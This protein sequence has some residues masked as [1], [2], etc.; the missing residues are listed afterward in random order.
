MDNQDPVSVTRIHWRKLFPWLNLLQAAWIGVRV[1]IL[2]PAAVLLMVSAA[3]PQLD[4]AALTDDRPWLTL[5][6]PV[7]AIVYSVERI[8]L[9][10]GLPEAKSAAVLVWNVLVLGFLGLAIARSSASEFCVGVRV[11]AIAGLRFAA[12]RAFAWLL[13][14]GIAVLLAAVFA[15]P[16]LVVIGISQWWFHDTILPQALWLASAVLAVLALLAGSVCL[17]GWFLAMAAIGTDNCSGSDALSR[18]ISYVLSHPWST[19]WQLLIITVAAS[20]VRQITAVVLTASLLLLHSRA[21][22]TYPL[23]AVDLSTVFAKVPDVS[24]GLLAHLPDLTHLGVFLS[25]LTVMYVL[26]RQKEDGIQLQE[27]DGSRS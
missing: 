8:A 23:S 9:R 4:P 6:G 14:T 12:Q 2:L 19:L 10:P 16:M 21:P 3:G 26:L 27:L 22:D 1:R 15:M 25:G 24:G 11:G 17:I 13:S 7:A 18:G 20:A 5:P